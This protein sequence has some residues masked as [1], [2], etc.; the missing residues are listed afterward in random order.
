MCVYYQP[1][2]SLY[3]SSGNIGTWENRWFGV[4]KSGKICFKSEEAPTEV[5]STSQ[6]RERERIKTA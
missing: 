2:A 6:Q 1:L 4:S 5:V 3:F